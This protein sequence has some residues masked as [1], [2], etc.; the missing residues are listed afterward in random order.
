MSQSTQRF[1]RGRKQ[2]RLVTWEGAANQRCVG[3]LCSFQVLHPGL[4]RHDG[5]TDTLVE[6][7][8]TVDVGG[9][10]EVFVSD[11]LCGLVACAGRLPEVSSGAETLRWTC[12]VA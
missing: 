12:A 11:T 5:C 6:L 1:H 7:D 3:S 4:H 2:R 10:D 9:V 8:R